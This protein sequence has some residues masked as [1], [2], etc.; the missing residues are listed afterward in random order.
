[1]KTIVTIG[2]CVRNCENLLGDA[3]KSIIEQDFSHEFM[4]MVF[5]DDGSEDKTLQ[6][7]QD[8]VSRTDIKSKVFHTKW[9][10]LGP[11]RQLAFSNAD[12]IYILWVDGDEI[13]SKSYVRE[14]V[15]FMEKNR[16]VGIT[17]GAVRPYDKGLIIKLDL[18]PVMVDRML[19]EK[20]KSFLWKTRKLPGTGGA[21]FRIEA[22]RQVN[23]FDER[24]TG[25]GE[26]MDVAKR[27]TAAN[28][29]IKYNEAVFYERKMKMLTIAD[30][31]GKYFWYGYGSHSVYLKDKAIVSLPRMTPPAGFLT[32]FFYSILAYKLMRQKAVFL[33]PSLFSLKMTAWCLGFIKS[34]IANVGSQKRV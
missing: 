24:I 27:I 9:R 20:P 26:D 21:T 4:E 28:W 32:G 25:A 22:L 3:I 17:S 6:I 7:I 10:G 5:V 33:L 15:E 11:A 16:K 19:F 14:Q 2:M 13:L 31:L 18:L 1:M 29:S 8:Y 23:G 30:L 12:G 34:Q